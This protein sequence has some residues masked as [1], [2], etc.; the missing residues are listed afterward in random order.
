[1]LNL[2]G[3][4]KLVGNNSFFS[5]YIVAYFGET[6]FIKMK[7]GKTILPEIKKKKK[8]GL[9]KCL[10]NLYVTCLYCLQ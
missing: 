9:R 1:M 5:F 10:I 2:W 3:K 8:L 6:M 4:R 7:N